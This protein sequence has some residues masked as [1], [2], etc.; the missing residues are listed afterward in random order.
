MELHLSQNSS[1]ITNVAVHSWDDLTEGQQL[2]LEWAEGQDWDR[3]KGYA[4]EYGPEVLL[5]FYSMLVDEEW[6]IESVLSQASDH[7]NV[8]MVKLTLEA[9]FNNKEAMDM[10]AIISINNSDNSTILRL[11]LEHGLDKRIII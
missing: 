8:E 5:G 10:A 2:C 1:E 4:K 3:V 9:G 7:D 6:T 11:L